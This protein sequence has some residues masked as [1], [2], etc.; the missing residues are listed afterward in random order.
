VSTN[1]DSTDTSG[2]GLRVA[3]K[4]LT[5]VLFF[6]SL[7]LTIALLT[8]IAAPTDGLAVVALVLAIVSLFLQI[9]FYTRQETETRRADVDA[10]RFQASVITQFDAI[11]NL[12][13]TIKG[14]ILESLELDRSKGSS[15]TTGTDASSEALLA[16][17]GI[18]VARSL[19]PAIE[20]LKTTIARF[21][22][23]NAPAVSLAPLQPVAGAATATPPRTTGAEDVT[24]IWELLTF[25]KD[26]KVGRQVFDAIQGLD[27]YGRLS[28][29]RLVFDEIRSRVIGGVPGLPTNEDAVDK[30][31]VRLGLAEITPVP[32]R[33]QEAFPSAQSWIRLTRLGRLAGSLTV[34]TGLKKPKY[35]EGRGLD[36]LTYAELPENPVDDEEEPE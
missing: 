8:Q 3:W 27:K 16:T 20:D 18:A 34:P 36:R 6:I 29:R 9:A 21:T 1:P 32:V 35:L 15:A 24:A 33:Q 17:V 23:P 22:S 25:P 26:K 14:H 4:T 19:E 30:E 2:P 11:K 31:L 7:G 5:A 13:A 12:P 10:A 28:V